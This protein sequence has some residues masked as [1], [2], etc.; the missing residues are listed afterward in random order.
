MSARTQMMDV[1]RQGLDDDERQFLMSVV[2]AE[3]DWSLLGIE[4]LAQLPGIRW[5]L[6]NL[7]QLRRAD[8][9]KFAAQAEQLSRLLAR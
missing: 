4:H 8:R 3:P 9:R 5:K 2:T 7:A 1:L 6:Q